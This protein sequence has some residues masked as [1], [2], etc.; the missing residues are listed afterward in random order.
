VFDAATLAEVKR[1]P[2]RKPVAKY[3]VGDRIQRP[4]GTRH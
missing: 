1:M 2:M 4:E 3:N